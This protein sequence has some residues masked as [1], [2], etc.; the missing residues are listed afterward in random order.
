MKQRVSSLRS[1]L[2]S[3]LFWGLVVINLLV[4]AY[5]NVPQSE[6]P[7]QTE[8]HE[9]IHPDRIRLL[10]PSE[11]D[12]LPVKSA[13]HEPVAPIEPEEA[14][15]TS[16]YE[17]GNFTVATLAKARGLLD[18]KVPAIAS[19]GIQP[20]YVEK[21]HMTAR[22]WVYIPPSPSLAEAQR[23]MAELASRGVGDSFVMQEGEWQY[24]ISLGLFKEERLAGRLLQQLKQQG[25]E[26][27]RQGVKLQPS[28]RKVLFMTDVSPVAA[29]QLYAATAGFKDSELKQVLC[30]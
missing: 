6:M 13:A 22:Y 17:W 20:R 29:E 28:G 19:N 15:I 18:S 30:Q 24:A 11:F 14:T 27:A 21:P 25:V 26:N 16:C 12:A 1:G 8:H 5:F 4:L 9:P 2:I 23:I 7:V 10:S 3:G